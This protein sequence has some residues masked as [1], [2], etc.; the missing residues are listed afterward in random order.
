MAF[1]SSVG[2][3]S[4]REWK[5]SARTGPRRAIRRFTY[6][7]LEH[8]EA[9]PRAQVPDVV[10]HAQRDMDGSGLVEPGTCLVTASPRTDATTV[11]A[12]PCRP[13][14]PAGPA[15]HAAAARPP[16][17]LRAPDRRGAPRRHAPRTP[18]RSG[19]GCRATPPRRHRAAPGRRAAA[20]RRPAP[21]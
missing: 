15:L 13:R 14:S 6:A 1:T 12:V 5:W 7:G 9:P 2:V 18:R 10:G 3:R 4:R 20:P 16:P 21:P 11:R 19:A 17:A 8:L